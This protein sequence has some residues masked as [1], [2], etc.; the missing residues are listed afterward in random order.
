MV[1]LGFFVFFEASSTP[2]LGL[3]LGTLWLRAAC[4]I[5]WASQAPLYLLYLIAAPRGRCYREAERD[6]R[7]DYGNREEIREVCDSHQSTFKILALKGFS[8]ITKF[9]D[10]SISPSSSGPT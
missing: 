10:P 9:K 6:L 3:E 5:D 8:K 4:S 1:F 2:S 7:G